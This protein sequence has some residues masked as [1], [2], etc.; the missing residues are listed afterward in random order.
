MLENTVA[1]EVLKK[2]YMH[3]RGK[4][5]QNLQCLNM[6]PIPKPHTCNQR[7]KYTSWLWLMDLVV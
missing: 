6:E 1:C 5:P 2:C 7:G 3:E 4:K